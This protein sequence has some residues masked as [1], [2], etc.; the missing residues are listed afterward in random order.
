MQKLILNHYPPVIRQIKDIQQIAT[1]EDIEFSKLN[2]AT[3]Q[4][5]NNMFVFSANAD[6]V[7]RFETLLGIKPK[8]AQSLD[9]RK[10]YIVSMLNRRKMSLTELTTML[11]NYS[12][13]IK[14]VNDM[15]NMEILVQTGQNAVSI[16]VINR[17]LDEIL[18]LNIYYHFSTNI[19]VSAKTELSSIA[20]NRLRLKVKPY[21]PKSVKA[22][23]ENN[24]IA[25]TFISSKLQIKPILS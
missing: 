21:L 18:P 20:K 11:S 7:R 8:A 2:A 17:I 24:I 1:A 25:A 22:R 23:A 15:A 6:G 10:L 9:D 5:I 19:K 12:E 16:D 13:G 4:V 3:N 14:L